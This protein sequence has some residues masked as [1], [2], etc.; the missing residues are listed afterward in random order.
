ML[1]KNPLSTFV[2][3]PLIDIRQKERIALEMAVKV[4][5]VNGPL[6]NNIASTVSKRYV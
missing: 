1:E 3:N 2:I 5:S 6:D 4:A